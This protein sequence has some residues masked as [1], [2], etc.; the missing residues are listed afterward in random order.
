MKKAIL[1]MMVGRGLI[2]GSAYSGGAKT[3]YRSTGRET[4]WAFWRRG[5]S[6]L[7]ASAAIIRQAV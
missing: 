6:E 4:H 3:Q 7:L 1:T 5:S 2:G